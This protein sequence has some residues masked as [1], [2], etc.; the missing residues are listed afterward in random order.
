[1]NTIVYVIAAAIVIGVIAVEMTFGLPWISRVTRVADGDSV[2]TIT[3]GKLRRIRLVGVD[4]PEYR[5]DHGKA[6]RKALADMVDRRL[7]LF[8]PNGRD[9]YDRFPCVMITITGPVSWRM[10]LAGHAWPDS[11]ATGILHLPARILRRGLWA[12]PAMRPKD[13]RRRNPR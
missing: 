3:R 7:V 4:A 9:V 13:W 6:A 1:M 11:I 2:E 10:A 5:Q 8:V 12:G